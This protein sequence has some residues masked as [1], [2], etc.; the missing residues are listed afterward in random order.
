[1]TWIAV[2]L[3]LLVIAPFIWT[4]INPGN[5]PDGAMEASFTFFIGVFG[6]AIIWGCYGA[7]RLVMYFL[8]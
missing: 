8:T 5:G 2:V 4:L 1:M 3:S 7:I 6:T